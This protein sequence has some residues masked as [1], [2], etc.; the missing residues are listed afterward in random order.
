MKMTLNKLVAESTKRVEEEKHTAYWTADG[1]KFYNKNLATWYETTKNSFVTFVDTNID[2]IRE[3]LSDTSVDM[4]KDYNKEYLE[5]LKSNYDKVNLWFGGGADCLTILETAVHN[6]IKLDKLILL[7]FDNINYLHNREVKECALPVLEKYAGQFGSYEIETTTFDNMRDRY[8]DELSFFVARSPF[9][10]PFRSDLHTI[11]SDKIAYIKGADKPQM[12]RHNNKWY[13][14]FLDNQTGADWQCSNL[15][16]FWLD[17]M[18]IKSYIKD[19]LLYREY[20]LSSDLVDASPHQFFKP[21]QDPTV[22]DVLGRSKV[23]NFNKQVLKN[24]Q[25][26]QVIGNKQ[27][28]FISSILK[29]NQTDILINYFTAMKKFNTMLPNTGEGAGKFAWL[30]DIDSLEVFTQQQ[31]IPNGFEGV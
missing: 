28:Q 15:K 7:T 12:V 18:N 31:L 25:S 1:Y 17:P 16:L 27:I 29:N 24:P 30:I 4:S 14:V 20:L 3:Q 10:L 6:N 11:S 9:K 23:H 22:G 5:Y 26:T 13:A 19:A 8:K 21:S 2:K